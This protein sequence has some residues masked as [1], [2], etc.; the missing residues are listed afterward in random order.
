MCAPI[1]Y[2]FSTLHTS[3]YA[4]Q[5]PFSPPVPSHPLQEA[6]SLPSSG[7]SV[8]PLSVKRATR[9]QGPSWLMATTYLAGAQ[10]GK[11]SAG[12]AAS[13]AGGRFAMASSQPELTREQQLAD[14]EVCFRIPSPVLLRG[15]RGGDWATTALMCCG[16]TTR[17]KQ[18]YE[19]HP[20][21]HT[22]NHVLPHAM[23]CPASCVTLYRR[24]LL[25]LQPHS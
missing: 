13:G 14:I 15:G 17:Q 2:L 8:S 22:H 4:A 10:A 6:D 18:L 5:C 24:H 1:P 16:C 23:R 25:Q 21:P 11:R 9:G 12:A 20:P 19:L 7:K 3:S